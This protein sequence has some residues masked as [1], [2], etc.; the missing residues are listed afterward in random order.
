MAVGKYIPEMEVLV[1]QGSYAD[2]YFKTVDIEKLKISFPKSKKLKKPKG[3]DLREK[4][5]KR[6]AERQ[7]SVVAVKLKK[8][9]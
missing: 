8:D 7:R 3:S 5:K 2:N 4:L 9:V 6:L 1:V